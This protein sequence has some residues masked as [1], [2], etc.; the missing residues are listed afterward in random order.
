ML[1]AAPLGAI[2]HS[3]IV[4]LASSHHSSDE[5]AASASARV[6]V[7]G[8]SAESQTDPRPNG[9]AAV[10]AAAS[11][12][13]PPVTSS[14]GMRDLIDLNSNP[15]STST[16]PLLEELPPEEGGGIRGASLVVEEEREESQAPV[17]FHPVTPEYEPASSSGS[18]L[19]DNDWLDE[20][21][22]PRRGRY[23]GGGRERRG[24]I[25][26]PPCRSGTSEVSDVMAESPAKES[27]WPRL[28]PQ[29]E[30]A[31]EP[32][33]LLL[34]SSAGGCGVGRCCRGLEQVM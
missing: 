1:N 18:S 11:I 2:D 10:T 16:T 31:A 32:N 15:D 27:Q 9:L 14:S 7:Q 29:V 5:S 20:D 6:S 26:P 30:V 34:G 8:A 13:L 23:E 22:L 17:K 21:L 19:S 4:P 3:P 25:F 24:S 33:N 28:S 12:Q